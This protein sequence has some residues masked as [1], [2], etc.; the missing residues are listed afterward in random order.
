MLY[1]CSMALETIS[2]CKMGA[3]CCDDVSSGTRRLMGHQ[4]TYTIVDTL[5]D[6]H[7][8]IGRLFGRLKDV[9]GVYLESS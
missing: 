7:S 6:S 4:K 1:N 3:I 5:G 2:L 8:L 9:V